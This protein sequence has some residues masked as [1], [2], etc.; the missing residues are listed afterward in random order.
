MTI[1][2]PF[3]VAVLVANVEFAGFAP[4]QKYTDCTV[5]IETVRTAKSLTRKK[6][7]EHRDLPRTGFAI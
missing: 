2:T 6:Q 5:S 3:F 4:K 7:S 1:F